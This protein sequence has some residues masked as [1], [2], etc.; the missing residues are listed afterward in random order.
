VKP[1]Y[2]ARSPEKAI[3]I[4]FVPSGTAYSKDGPCKVRD[5]YTKDEET[6][7]MLVQEAVLNYYWNL[8][9]SSSNTL[10]PDYRERMNFYYYWRP[11]KTAETCGSCAGT[12]PDTFWTDAYFADVA[13]ILYPPTT[14]GYPGCHGCASML[15]PAKS[16]FAAPGY[17]RSGRITVHETGHAVFALVDTYCGDTY[18][19]Q[20]NPHPNVWASHQDCFISMLLTN[21]NPTQCRQILYDNPNTAKNP[22]CSREF[23]KWDPDPDLMR[24]L[25]GQFH[26]MSVNKINYIFDTYAGA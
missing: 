19:T 10:R 7:R 14:P 6:F 12:L 15:G 2:L 8:Q 13:G 17:D 26:L 5:T 18:Y 4:V 21:R 23:W 24:T 25:D 1:V 3:D 9:A 11:G 20:N 16:Q 22:D